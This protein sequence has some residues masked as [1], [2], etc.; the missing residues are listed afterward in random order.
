MET[1]RWL[2]QFFQAVIKQRADELREYFCEDAIIRWH[3]TNERFSVE[4]Y[5]RAN[6]EYPGDW[7]GELERIVEKDALLITTARIW[8]REGASFHV[9]SFYTLEH[10]K[11]KALDEY[12]GDDGLPPLWRQKKQLGSK[13]RE[14]TDE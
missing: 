9:V 13:L 11:I 4:E 7:C 14:L 5:I 2:T 1:N 10:G 6:C 3:C 8:E 12:W